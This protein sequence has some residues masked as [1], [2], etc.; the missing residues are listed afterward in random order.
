MQPTLDTPSHAVAI[1][2]DD[3]MDLLSEISR[4]TDHQLRFIESPA[5]S[6]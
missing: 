3:A 4:L 2:G 6:K 1:G 5:T